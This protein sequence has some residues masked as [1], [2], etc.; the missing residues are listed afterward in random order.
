MKLL[1]NHRITPVNR[2]PPNDLGRAHD[3]ANRDI[4]GDEAQADGEIDEGRFQP[5]KMVMT[6]M[7]Q[8]AVNPPSREDRNNLVSDHFQAS[9][10]NTLEKA[11][12]TNAVKSTQMAAWI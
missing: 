1:G 9:P 6:V 10:G 8:R 5:S 11:G 3:D 4:A 7:D 2:V 12:N